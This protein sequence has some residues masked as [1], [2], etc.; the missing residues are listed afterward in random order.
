M[1]NDETAIFQLYHGENMLQSYDH[2]DVR[3]I[4]DQHAYVGFVSASSLKQQSIGRHI[5]PRGHIILNP[6][7]QIFVFFLLNIAC[8]EEEQQLP[9][10]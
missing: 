7:Q 10:S 5:A 4:Q 8:L 9:I 6:S 3:F 2:D 1:S